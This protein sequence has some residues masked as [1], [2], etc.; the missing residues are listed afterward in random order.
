MAAD[1]PD[2]TQRID[3]FL[4]F[5]RLAKTRGVAQA[6]CEQGHIRLDG[7]RIGRAHVA[8]RPG[9]VLS[10]MAH[11][12]VRVLRIER[13]PTRRGPASEAATLYREISP[14]TP[15]ETDD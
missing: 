11:G 15:A 10:L 1:A 14:A 5:A 2:G 3:R 12:R 4:W 6:L 7:R 9:N 13:L 8:V